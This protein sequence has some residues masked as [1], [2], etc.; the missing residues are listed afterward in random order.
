M[1]D[2]RHDDMIESNSTISRRRVLKRVGAAAVGAVGLAALGQNQ[3]SAGEYVYCH[4]CCTYHCKPKCKKGNG[5]NG[6]NGRGPQGN[7]GYG[8]GGD[9]GIPG[10]SGKNISDDENR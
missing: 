8:N 5:G 3:A 9:D 4:V 6:G 10:G 1:D 2:R 7:N